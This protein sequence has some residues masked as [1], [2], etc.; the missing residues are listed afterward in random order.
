MRPSVL[1]V[2]V[3]LFAASAAGAAEAPLARIVLKPSAMTEAGGGTIEV[4]EVFPDMAVA[5]GRP[6]LSIENRAPGM[7]G[8]QAMDGLAVTDEA[9]PVPLTPDKAEAPT[10]WAAGRAVRGALTVRYRLPVANDD[11]ATGGPP[12]NLRV[13]GDGVSAVGGFPDWRGRRPRPRTAWP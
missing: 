11:R 9:G 1:A 3:G 12:I 8:P 7:T 2:L 10:A 6:L 13:D 4:A 5:A